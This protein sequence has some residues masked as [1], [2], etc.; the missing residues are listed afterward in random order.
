MT[1]PAAGRASKHTPADQGFLDGLTTR[2]LMDFRDYIFSPLYISSNAGKF[3]DHEWIDIPILKESELQYL[4]RTLGPDRSTTRPSPSDPIRIKIEAPSAFPSAVKTEPWAARL[5]PAPGDIR[6]RTLNEG[7]VEVFEL[8]S[9]SEPEPSDHNS[10]LEVL[11]ALQ[12]TSRSSSAIPDHSDAHADEQ[13]DPTPSK[14]PSALSNAVSISNEQDHDGD[15]KKCYDPPK[16]TESHTLWQDD[17]TSFWRVGK[18]RLTQKV[19]VDCVE[20]LSIP[21]S[22]YPIPREPTA[23][24]VDLS[25]EKYNLEDPTTHELYTIDHIIRNADNDSWDS[26]SGGHKSKAYVRFAPGEKAIECRC[27]RSTC[28]GAHACERID[29]ELRHA[30]RF[31]L[32]PASRDRVIAASVDTRRNE[33]TTPEQHV[34]LFMKI[35]RDGKCL[36]INSKGDKCEGAPIMLAKP[37]GTT[38]DHQYFIG[39]SGRTPKFQKHHRVLSIPDYVRENLLVKALA[40]QQLMD[41]PEKD[42]NLCSGDKHA[43]WPSLKFTNF[44]VLVPLTKVEPGFINILP[45]ESHREVRSVG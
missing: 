41:D 32:D 44:C 14:E 19:T 40:G 18:Y 20:Y 35:I 12:P 16:L 7:G 5:P 15:F 3:L 22:I 23:F 31:E 11:T 26:G 37:K 6:L 38:R 33:A 29:P 10:D 45:I 1:V 27:A 25:D 4:A 9:D 39:C 36:A 34:A 2:Q 28:K 43:K 42:T 21:A 8:L 13:F 30:V 17:L 24:V